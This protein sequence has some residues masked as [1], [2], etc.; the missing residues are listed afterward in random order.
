[1]KK[2]I[3]FKVGWKLGILAIIAGCGAYIWQEFLSNITI[4][5]LLTEN[6]DLRTA[7]ANINEE[8]KIGYAKVID[9]ETKD[10]RL[11]TRLKFIETDADDD[12]KILL[13]REYQ[14]EGDVIHFDAL[15]VKFG[16]EFVMDGREKAIYL[17]RRVYSDKM[18]PEAGLQ[19]EA[20][21]TEPRRYQDICDKLSI[22]KRDMFWSEI[23]DLSNN[24]EKLNELGIT[25]VYGNA[26]YKKLRKGLIYVFKIKNTGEL[27][28]ETIPD[29]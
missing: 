17:W 14:I 2:S 22:Q 6:R 21:G 23:W 5:R 20:F 10:G 4:S 15:I 18:K 7:I 26:V 13:E 27:Y 24:P 19:I 25:A 16:S 1:M 8:T 12:S 3:L 9:Q 29:M 28:P 11:F